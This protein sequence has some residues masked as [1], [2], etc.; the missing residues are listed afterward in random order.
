MLKTCV[1]VVL[2]RN[3]RRNILGQLFQLF[4]YLMFRTQTQWLKYVTQTCDLNR[5]FMVPVKQ[6]IITTESNKII[7]DPYCHSRILIHPK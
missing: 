1:N 7:M 5:Y 4:T 3:S 2:T 6:G